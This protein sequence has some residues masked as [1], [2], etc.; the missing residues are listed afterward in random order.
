MFYSKT[1]NNHKIW[2]EA[3]TERSESNPGRSLGVNMIYKTAV[4]KTVPCWRAHSPLARSPGSKSI[5][6]NADATDFI[7]SR[8]FI[9][10]LDFSAPAGRWDFHGLTLAGGILR[11]TGANT[12]RKKSNIKWQRKIKLNP[13]KD[14]IRRIRV[15]CELFERVR[16]EP[17]AKEQE[18]IRPPLIP[19]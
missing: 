10:L 11:R 15:I 4:W 18:W 14:K 19:L 16:T 1:T 8:I 9:V 6:D 13:W 5:T 3:N 12:I 2:L 17:K 7:F